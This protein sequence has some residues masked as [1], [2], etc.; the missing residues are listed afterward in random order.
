MIL[1]ILIQ[2]EIIVTLYQI[3]YINV[4]IL[5]LH[6]QLAMHGVIDAYPLFNYFEIEFVSDTSLKI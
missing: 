3:A 4:V 5:M 1:T 2:T 6:D